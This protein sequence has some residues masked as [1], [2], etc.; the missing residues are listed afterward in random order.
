MRDSYPGD[1]SREQFESIQT[2][3]EQAEKKTRPRVINSR[4]K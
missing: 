2:L 4:N 3:C 1:I